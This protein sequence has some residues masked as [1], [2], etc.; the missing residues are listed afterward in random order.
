MAALW[1][2]IF[3]K[4]YHCEFTGEDSD[5]PNFRNLGY[6]IAT[7]VD[8]LDRGFRISKTSD[9]SSNEFDLIS[10]ENVSRFQIAKFLSAAS[11]ENT[12]SKCN[13]DY[14]STCKSAGFSLKP[15]TSSGRTSITDGKI[16]IVHDICIDGEIFEIPD[17]SSVVVKPLIDSKQVFML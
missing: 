12:S 6:F 11:C 17:G 15:S 1:N 4:T 5:Q 7:K 16:G 3:F 10:L 14:V 8:F 2:L 9:I 13:L